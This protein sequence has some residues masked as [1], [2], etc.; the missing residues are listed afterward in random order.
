[1]DGMV[2]ADDAFMKLRSESRGIFTS[3]PGIQ[4]FSQTR[5]AFL[6]RKEDAFLWPD[7]NPPG[8]QWEC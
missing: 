5:H 8:Y 2:L 7:H 6:L 3:L 1:M 4:L